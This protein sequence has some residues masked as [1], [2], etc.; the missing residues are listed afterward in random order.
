MSMQKYGGSFVSNIGAALRVADS[1]NAS[2]IKQAFP[3][4]W[5]KYLDMATLST[6]AD[7]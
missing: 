6:P 3:E 7:Q 1:D 2:R 5:Q 4:Y